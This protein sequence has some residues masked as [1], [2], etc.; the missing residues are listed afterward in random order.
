MNSP[1]ITQGPLINKFEK[2]VCRLLK[3]KYAV[4]VNSCTS[5]LQIAI[6]ASN[7]KNAN[8]I[9]SPVSFVSTSNSIL[10]NSL[11][12]VFVDVDPESLNLDLNNVK[13]QLKKNKRIKGIV[14]V[15][16]GGVAAESKELFNLAKK[17]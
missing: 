12:P 6:Q 13:F 1:F 16:L 4:A 17:K 15:H 14:P 5:G 8:L 7:I 2:A 10:F 9:T 3:V 11:K